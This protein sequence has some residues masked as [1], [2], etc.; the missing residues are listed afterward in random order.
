MFGLFEVVLAI[1]KIAY[2]NIYHK[3]KMLLNNRN[4]MKSFH[5]ILYVVVDFIN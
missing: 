2:L 4:R 3:Q 5:P 1:A